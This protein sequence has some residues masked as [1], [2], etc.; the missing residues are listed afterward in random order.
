MRDFLAEMSAAL[1]VDGVAESIPQPLRQD[2]VCLMDAILSVPGTSTAHLRAFNW[3]WICFG[4]VS[5]SELST[6]N[7]TQ[8]SRAAWEGARTRISPL[9]WPYQTK[10]GPKSFRIWRRLLATAFLRGHRARVSL[11]TRN[12]DLRRPL[13]RWLHMSEA[14]FL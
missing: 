8:L 4:V 2:D 9:L 1:F 12:L 13:G 3:C 14:I 6:A 11:R 7:G 10:P 5:V